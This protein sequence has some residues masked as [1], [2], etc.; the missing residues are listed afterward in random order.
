MRRIHLP[1]DVVHCHVNFQVE[2]VRVD[3][4]VATDATVEVTLK[5]VVH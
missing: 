4:V 5:E 2:G 3:L 1:T